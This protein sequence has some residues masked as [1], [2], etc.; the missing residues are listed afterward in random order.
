MGHP[1]DNFAAPP[2]ADANLPAA[3]SLA[4]SP[5]DITE[6]R[7]RREVTCVRLERITEIYVDY[8][9]GEDA[10]RMAAFIEHLIQSAQAA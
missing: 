10:A 9:A 7:A 4:D 8:E 5:G 1:R 6:S 3:G 2:E